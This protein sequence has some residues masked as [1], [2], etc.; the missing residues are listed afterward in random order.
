MH[1]VKKWPA[2][3]ASGRQSS[4]GLR[5]IE[6]NVVLEHHAVDPVDIIG[7]G[8]LR[9]GQLQPG[10]AGEQFA[11]APSHAPFAHHEFI[12]PLEL[13]HAEGSL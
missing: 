2:S 8:G 11:I 10:D 13:R 9:Q 4:N 6:R 7:V 12:Q 3:H 1:G 5:G